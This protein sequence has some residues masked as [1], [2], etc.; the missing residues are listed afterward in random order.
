MSVDPTATDLSDSRRSTE[1]A[2]KIPT[3]SSA[4]STTPGTFM[5]NGSSSYKLHVS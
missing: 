1:P 4:P 2:L 5:A 3:P